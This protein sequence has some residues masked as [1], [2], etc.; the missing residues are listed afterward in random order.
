MMSQNLAQS[1]S[2]SHLTGVSE[3][4]FYLTLGQRRVSPRRK[5]RLHAQIRLG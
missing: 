1:G 5:K 3:S 4:A 2:G